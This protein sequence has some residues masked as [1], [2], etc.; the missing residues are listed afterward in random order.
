[1]PS[2]PALIDR[3]GGRPF[4]AGAHRTLLLDKPDRICLVERGYVDVF[5]AELRGDE[6]VNRRPFVTRIP[7]GSVAFGAPRAVVGG[8]AFG[9]LAVPSR[10]AVLIEG[11]RSRLADEGSLDLRLVAWVDTWVSH[12][13]EVLARGAGPVPRGTTLLEADPDV[14]Y[15]AGVTLSAHHL[16]VVWISADRPVRLMGDAG[17]RMEAGDI[18]PLSERTWVATDAEET[19]VSAV[20]TPGAFLAATLW[21]ALDRFAE[22]ILRESAKATEESAQALEERH[23]GIREVQRS[24]GR[25]MQRDLESALGTREHD[26]G[27]SEGRSP[28]EAALELVAASV[29]VEGRLRRRDARGRAAKA[30]GLYEE[31]AR[32]SAVRTRR[33]ALAPEWWRRDGP[34]FAGLTTEGER[35]IAVLSDGRG[36][37]R[38]VDPAADRSFRIGHKEAAGIVSEGVMLYAPFPA[39]V[40]GVAAALRHAG[41][42]MKGEFREL[43]LVGLLSA[44]VG[45]AT[46]IL[47][48][49]LLATAIPRSDTP[50][51]IAGLAALFLCAVGAAVFQIVQSFALM[52]IEGR[53]DEH[54][55]G[56]LWSRV[57]SLPVGFFRG[58]AAG[59][60]ADRL[61]GLSEVRS[62]LSGAVIRSVVSGLFALSGFALLLYYSTRL[63][64]VAG[65]MLLGLTAVSLFLTRM[66]TRHHR[67]ARKAQGLI[68]AMVFQMITGLAKLRVA[69][70]EP[71]LLARWARLFA[72]RQRATLGARRWAAIQLA[73]DGLFTPLASAVL[74]A[75]IW[76]FLVAGD[77]GSSFGLAGFLIAFGAFGQLAGAFSGLIASAVAISAVVPLFERVRP[78]LDAEPETAGAGTDPLDLTGEIELRDVYFRYVRE[79]EYVLKGVSLRIRP[80]DYIAL[81]GPSGS[82][83][84]T[85]QRLMVGFEHP[86]SGAVFFDGHD[87]L[88]LDPDAVRRHLGVVLQT[89]Q[90]TADTISNNI[91]GSLRLSTDEIWDAVRAA[92]LEDDVRAMPMGLHTMLHEGGGGLSGGQRQRLM[93][94]RALA[95]QPRVLLL[96]EATSAMDNETQ[97]VVQA[98]LRKLNIT[99]IVIAH[100]LS[101]VRDVDRIYVLD[102][103]RIVETGRY[104][105]LIAR[106]GL[107]A[108]LA[109]RQLA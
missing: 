93:V 58:Y 83:K 6:V 14:P 60:L 95:R 99:R 87:L 70:A 19:R 69:N 102:R 51:W 30:L 81:V 91:A 37:F 96:D 106:N 89:G 107:F 31:I 3:I 45:L 100:R 48:G 62:I 34:S 88:N 57:L 4:G 54:L 47:T 49:H 56:A 65:A 98:S 13:S 26:L 59:D 39:R 73:I 84:S 36:R 21:P 23:Q 40:R 17:L 78:L 74:L 77:E 52:R 2:S 104:D 92:G 33:I 75:V 1:M 11:K 22:T 28:T 79:S 90:V 64:I 61:G 103:G 15:A 63:A 10:D 101:T 46:P 44:L 41:S 25:A 68:E 50:M 18:V 20:H 42:R 80:G 12:L 67:K 35:P 85:I 32:A 108:E 82:G 72:R 43:L 5:A 109:A 53:L 66:Q 71:Y 9:F 24:V 76:I 27:T 16:D 55:H 29:G 97:A 7:T 38:A 86:D 8:R 105:D 94:A